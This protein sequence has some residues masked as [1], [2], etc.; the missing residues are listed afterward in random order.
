[1][2]RESRG[3]RRHLS[4]IFHL[5]TA[6]PGTKYLMYLRRTDIQLQNGLRV[7]SR[8]RSSKNHSFKLDPLNIH[9]FFFPSFF[10]LL[11]LAHKWTALQVTLSHAVLCMQ[12]TSSLD[13]KIYMV[14]FARCQHNHVAKSNFMR[15]T[16][17]ERQIRDNV[18]PF[19][20]HMFISGSVSKFAC[21]NRLLWHSDSTEDYITPRGL[22]HR[23]FDKGKPIPSSWAVPT[24]GPSTLSPLKKMM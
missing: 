20:V 2:E 22:P 23:I 3:G 19:N 8:W 10:N 6:I 7:L 11:Y 9:T 21:E 4:G 15:W 24:K 1:M 12:Q 17:Y 5:S 13:M 16:H 14:N 18:I